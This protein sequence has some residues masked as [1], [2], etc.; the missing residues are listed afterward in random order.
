MPKF[1]HFWPP[2]C[3]VPENQNTKKDEQTSKI[4]RPALGNTTQYHCHPAISTQHDFEF[5]FKT[6]KYILY[7]HTHTYLVGGIKEK[8]MLISS[9]TIIKH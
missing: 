5:H 2:Y 6:H 9:D 1:P 4:Q 7:I 3:Q 8:T